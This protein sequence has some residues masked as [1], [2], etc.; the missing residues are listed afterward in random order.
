MSSFSSLC[1]VC[2]I[3]SLLE[4]LLSFWYSGQL[5]HTPWDQ[6]ALL[7]ICDYSEP[8]SLEQCGQP[9]HLLLLQQQPLPPFWVL[10]LYCHSDN[11]QEGRKHINKSLNWLTIF[12]SF[13]FDLPLFFVGKEELKDWGGLLGK[14]VMEG[15]RCRSCRNQ[16]TSSTMFCKA[17]LA[18]VQRKR[19]VPH[20]PCALWSGW[21]LTGKSPHLV[22]LQHVYFGW[23][24][25]LHQLHTASAKLSMRGLH[26]SCE[27]SSWPSV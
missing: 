1:L 11:P 6:R 4:P 7:R 5:Q 20:K 13:N 21:T 10:V 8:A 23:A 16:N 26:A 2:S 25:Q 19:E 14:G 24:L 15:R 27:A 17:T 22:L 3:Y 18:P 12:D 9:P